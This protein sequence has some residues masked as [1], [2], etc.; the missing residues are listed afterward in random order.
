[1]ECGLVYEDFEDIFLL[2]HP[3]DVC[4]DQRNLFLRSDTELF[5]GFVT[6]SL[7]QPKITVLGLMQCVKTVTYVL[8]P[9]ISLISY[10]TPIVFNMY[11]FSA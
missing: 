8:F 7:P 6:Q 9:D 5:P 3:V 11:Y 10:T 2:K 1:M 4:V